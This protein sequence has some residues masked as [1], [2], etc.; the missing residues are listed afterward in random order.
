M[1]EL[2]SNVGFIIQE[3]TKTGMNEEVVIGYNPRN[4]HK[5]VTWICYRGN[6]YNHGH[7]FENIEKAVQDYKARI[8]GN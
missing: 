1:D 7:Y 4:T 3:K 5:F 8:K 2:R 6:D